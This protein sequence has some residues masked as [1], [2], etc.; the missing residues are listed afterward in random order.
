MEPDRSPSNTDGKPF[1]FPQL[2]I[3]QGKMEQASELAAGEMRYTD[4]IAVNGLFQTPMYS[5]PSPKS[6]SVEASASTSGHET[7]QK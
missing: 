3:L 1:D 5:P 6:A 4:L 2:Q 7:L